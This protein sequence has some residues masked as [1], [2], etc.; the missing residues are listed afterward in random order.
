MDSVT[1]G[2]APRKKAQRELS[3]TELKALLDRT[4]VEQTVDTVE[5]ASLLRVKP[6]TMRRW[7]CYGEGPI[8]ARR[9]FGR[10]RWA[11]ADIEK[12]LSGETEVAA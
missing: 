6:Q 4:G 7:A 8:Q 5:A 1:T 10:L 3:N 11:V 2:H 12:V 9:A